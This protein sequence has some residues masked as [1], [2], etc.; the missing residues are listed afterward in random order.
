MADNEIRTIRQVRHDISREH[1][2][3]VDKVI[4]YYRK[5]EE[6]IKQTGEFRFV[7]KGGQSESAE[8][9]PKVRSRNSA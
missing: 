7:V 6:K 3:D 5:V 8:K 2:H 1:G 4:A 9:E